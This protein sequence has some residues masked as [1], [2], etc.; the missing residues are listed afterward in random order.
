MNLANIGHISKSVNII[1]SN[2]HDSP[3]SSRRQGEGE[4]KAMGFGLGALHG[5]TV[6][7]LRELT[8]GRRQKRTIKLNTKY[9][10]K[11]TV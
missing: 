4:I 10:K 9:F 1:H 7:P 8:L 11:R 5:R 3:R 2:A 6:G